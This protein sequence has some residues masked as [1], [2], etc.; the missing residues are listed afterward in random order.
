VG[1]A[2]LETFVL[3]GGAASALQSGITHVVTACL[4]NSLCQ[5]LLP[6]TY[7]PRLAGQTDTFHNFPRLLDPIIM[8][9]GEK[10]LNSPYIN[11]S[12][13]GT[14]KIANE[15]AVKVYEGVYQ[16]GVTIDG[17]VPTIVHHFFKPK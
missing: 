8:K 9:H 5:Q 1:A 15:G 12:I 4:M 13:E 3:G 2:A 10:A 6:K 11:Y 7:H 17:W 16:I 14:V